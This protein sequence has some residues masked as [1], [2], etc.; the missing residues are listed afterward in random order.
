M[1]PA[2][3]GRAPEVVVPAPEAGGARALSAPL[4]AVTEPRVVQERRD[5]AAAGLVA[6]RYRDR[7]LRHAQCLAAA[8]PLSRVRPAA[9]GAVTVRADGDIAVTAVGISGPP[10]SA[11]ISISTTTM[12]VTTPVIAL[13]AMTDTAAAIVGR[14]ARIFASGEDRHASRTQDFAAS[15]SVSV[16]VSES[17]ELAKAISAIV[18]ALLRFES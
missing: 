15:A 14:I 6:A 4:A 8:E 12:H 3:G 17:T 7:E 2:V 18:V 10:G 9:R 5:A 16:S 1:V 11:S 13:A